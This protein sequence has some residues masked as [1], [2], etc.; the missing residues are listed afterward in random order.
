MWKVEYTKRFL[1]ELSALPI[2]IRSRIEPI[3]F[4]SLDSTDPFELGYL[5]KMKG[6]PDKYKLRM[7]DYRIGITLD[8]KSQMIICERVAHRREIYRVFP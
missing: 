8:K 1:K 4:E 6:Y 5:E 2:E 3:V 7:G